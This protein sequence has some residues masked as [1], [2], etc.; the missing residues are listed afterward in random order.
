MARVVIWMSPEPGHILPTIKVASDLLNRGHA[1]LYLTCGRICQ[2]LRALGFSVQEMFGSHWPELNERSVFQ[3]CRSSRLMYSALFNRLGSGLA[4]SNAIRAD[5]LSCVDANNTDLLLVDGVFDPWL[6]VSQNT[7]C[8]KVFVHLPYSNEDSTY[9]SRN[10][11]LFL[12]PEAFEFPNAKIPG[13]Y[14]TEPALYLGRY[15]RVAESGFVDASAGSLVYCSLGAQLES[16]PDS[17]NIFGSMIDAAALMCDKQFVINAGIYTAQLSALARSDNVSVRS[18]VPH[19][20]VLPRASVAVI[21]GGF[22][23]IK[24]CIFFGVPMIVIPKF[25]DQPR[26]AERIQFHHLGTSLS[27]SALSG[28]SLARTIRDVCSDRLIQQS[29]TVMQMIFRDA[30]AEQRT[31]VLLE[32]KMAR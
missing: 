23:S 12:S 6:R 20:D 8:M 19:P 3:R 28:Q 27:P 29:L 26:N 5:I 2:E 13:A 18:F 15:G 4:C 31:A 11:L 22:G 1:V 9:D 24:E 21:H 10:D 14:Y 25:W 16:Y 17:L 32:T 7:N 30:Q